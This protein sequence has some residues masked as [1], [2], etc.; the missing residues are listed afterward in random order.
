MATLFRAAGV[1]LS[2][3]AGVMIYAYILDVEYVGPEKHYEMEKAAHELSNPPG[4]SE[5]PSF[6]EWSATQ[7]DRE[8]NFQAYLDALAAKVAVDAAD[9]LDW[10]REVKKD[11]SEPMSDF[12]WRARYGND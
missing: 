2:L 1:A 6:D 9:T 10:T 5:F 11:A 7:T 3:C 4:T 8:S 12:E